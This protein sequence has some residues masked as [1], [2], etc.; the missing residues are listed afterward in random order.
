MPGGMAYSKYTTSILEATVQLLV[1][2]GVSQGGFFTGLQDYR[3][4]G[5]QDYRIAGWAG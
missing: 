5:L 4:T 2:M 3:I 1:F